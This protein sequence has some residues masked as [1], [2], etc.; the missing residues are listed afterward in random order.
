M[1]HSAHRCSSALLLL[2]K[3]QR[4]AGSEAGR[5]G[6][7]TAQLWGPACLEPAGGAVVSEGHLSPS[8]WDKHT[9]Q[10]GTLTRPP[11]VLPASF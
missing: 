6:L 7:S 8:R 11:S 4:Q 2:P 3:W 1:K 5:Q 10:A 9:S